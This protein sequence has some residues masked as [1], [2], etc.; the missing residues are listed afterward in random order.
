MAKLLLLTGL[1][2]VGKTT[3]AAALPA[4]YYERVHFGGL[5][6]QVVEKN[7]GAVLPHEVF[8]ERFYRLVDAA[9]VRDAVLLARDLVS[10]STATVCVLDSHAVTQTPSGLRATPDDPKRIQLLRF[11]GIIHLSSSTCVERVVENS[12]QGGRLRMSADDVVVAEQ[13]QLAVCVTYASAHDCPL[14]V[15]SANG[16]SLTV[17]RRVDLAARSIV[18]EGDSD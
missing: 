12:C 18:T 7:L 5:L 17:L 11:D 4:P 6:R 8:R 1:P 13:V 9:V 10:Q 14:V 15:V 3:T 2:G 16:D